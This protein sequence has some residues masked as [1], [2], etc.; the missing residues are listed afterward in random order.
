MDSLL[1]LDTICSQI[2]AIS[3]LSC[4]PLIQCKK[5]STMH[6]M[7]CITA[8][9]ILCKPIAVTTKCL[10]NYKYSRHTA[11]YQLQTLRLLSC[12][13]TCTPILASTPLQVK[14]QQLLCQAWMKAGQT[15]DAAYNILITH[16]T[17]E[18]NI[19]VWTCNHCSQVKLSINGMCMPAGYTVKHSDSMKAQAPWLSCCN[20]LQ[21]KLTYVSFYSFPVFVVLSCFSLPNICIAYI[22]HQCLSN[23]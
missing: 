15:W 19:S 14:V 2:L 20:L 9:T 13:T 12:N 7:K 5:V 16:T 4:Q 17:S 3:T 18:G 21:Q 11:V 22:C 6:I 10:A 8:T 1:A 23:F